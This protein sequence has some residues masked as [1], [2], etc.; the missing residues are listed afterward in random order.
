MGGV[1][2]SMPNCPACLFKV[3]PGAFSKTLSHMWGKLNLPMFLFN[4]G[5]FTLIKIDSLVFL[6]KPCP[7]LPIIWKLLWLVGWPVLL[8]WWCIGEGFFRCSLNLCPKVLELSP[9]Y[10]SSQVRSPHWS[11]CMDPLLLTM[12]SLSLGETSSFLMVLLSLK[13]VCMKRSF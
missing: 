9:M 3:R 1:G 13:W 12:E 4:V 5:S 10:S 11:Q 6:A 2:I 7:S 8:L